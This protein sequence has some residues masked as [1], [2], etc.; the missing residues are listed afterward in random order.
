MIIGLDA[1]RANVAERTGTEHYAFEVLRRLPALLP[2]QRFVC[3]MR[4]SPRADLQKL[5]PNVSYRVLSWPPGILWSHLRLSWELLW[6]R[7]D[8]LFVPADTVPLIHPRRT[9]TTIHDVAFERWPELYR[10]AS[11]Q[12]RLTWL[13]PIVHAA[14]RLFTAGRYSASERDYH[15]WSARHALRASRLIFTVSEFSKR[16]I[17]DT[18]QA[19]PDRIMVTPLG[20]NQPEVYQQ[21]SSVDVSRTLKNLS[22]EHPFF[23]FIG[24]LESKKNISL[25]LKSF[26]LFCHTT[27]TDVD[28]VLAGRPGYGWDEAQKMI[29]GS[30]LGSRIHLVGWQP[31]ESIRILQKSARAFVFLSR[32]EGFGLPP[33]E[34]LSAGVPVLASAA[35]SLPEVLGQAALIESSQDP[36]V[37]AQGFWTIAEDQTVRRQLIQRG[38]EW[39][40]Q[41]TWDRTARLTAQILERPDLQN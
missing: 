20:V 35:G 36:A 34:S 9:Y 28:L 23:L 37:I 15:R 22:L 11:V 1:S 39:V 29:T 32:Y 19:Q 17:I 18:L 13:R 10:G 27:T 40:H 41:Y 3:Y 8:V 21:L 5:G 16:E 26:I 4:E 14:V 33:L 12:R 38:L 24:R 30:H 7:P 25:L 31:E 2:A 6:H